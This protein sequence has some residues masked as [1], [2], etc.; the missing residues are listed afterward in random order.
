MVQYAP[1][2]ENVRWVICVLLINYVL[3][4]QQV[5]CMLL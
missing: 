5:F 2:R 1:T 3:S 4:K